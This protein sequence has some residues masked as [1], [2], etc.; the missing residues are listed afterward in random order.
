MAINEFVSTPSPYE[1]RVFREIHAWRHREPSWLRRK[2]RWL[3]Q[4]LKQVSKRAMQIPGV[5]WTLDNLVVGLVQCANEIT[6]DTTSRTATIKSFRSKGHEVQTFSDIALL[7]LEAV[8]H[9]ISGLDLRYQSLTAAHGAAAGLAGAAGLIPDIVALVTLNLRVT[10]QI[11]LCCGYDISAPE[12][13]NYALNVLSVATQEEGKKDGHPGALVRKHTRSVME[14]ATV[15]VAL[16]GTARVLGTRL[17]KLKLAQV[18]PLAAVV[19]GGGFNAYYTARVCE[20]AR[21][22]YRERRLRNKYAD[23]ILNSVLKK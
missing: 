12:E 15:G 19:A 6:Q 17:I 5:E 18:I 2:V 14:Q 4:P 3:N 21:H 1:Q 11:A 16:R 13:R 20:T 22:L 23:S 7:D 9:V 8:D 10:G